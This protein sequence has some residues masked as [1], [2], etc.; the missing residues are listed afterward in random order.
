MGNPSSVGGVGIPSSVG[1]VTVQA[2]HLFPFFREHPQVSAGACR[3]TAGGTRRA[4]VVHLYRIFLPRCTVS[5]TFAATAQRA[6]D[7]ALSPLPP[8]RQYGLF[9][10]ARFFRRAHSSAVARAPSA[11]S[12]PPASARA[13]RSSPA[14]A[15]AE[16][17]PRARAIPAPAPAPPPAPSGG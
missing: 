13:A 15:A 14:T 5:H 3:G 6:P 16:R 1:V 4:C 8:H 17:D 9:L 12:A 7:A 11:A 10:H 2:P